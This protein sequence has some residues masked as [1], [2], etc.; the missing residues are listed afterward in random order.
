MQGG[1]DELVA[2][3]DER[4]QQRRER[5]TIESHSRA[6]GEHEEA[7]IPLTRRSR[8]GALW[9][10]N[11]ADTHPGMPTSS[12]RNPCTWLALTALLEKKGINVPT[13]L[14]DESRSWER[15]VREVYGTPEK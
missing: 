8:L 9:S 15:F 1:A 7:T 2:V 10:P 5:V 14:G 12:L 13:T 3:R 6:D 4:S 11:A